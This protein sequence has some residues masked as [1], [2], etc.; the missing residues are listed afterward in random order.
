[1]WPHILSLLP[2]LLLP[3]CVAEA[4]PLFDDDKVVDI[5]LIG[6]V[7][8]LIKPMEKREEM[9]FVL[10]ANGAEHEVMVRLRGKS[11]LRVCKFPP[12]RLRFNTEDTDPGLFTGQ[13][14]LRLVTHCKNNDKGE[15]NVLEEYAAYRIF[16]LLSDYAYRVRLFR[17]RYTDT[18]QKLSEK[19]ALRYGFAIEPM[20]QLAQR[21]GGEMLHVQSLSAS[22]YNREQA[23]LVFVFQYLIGNTDWSFV[24]AENDDACCHNGDLLEIDRSIYYI[25]YDFDLAGIVNAN[26]AKPDPGLRMKN[27][28]QRRYRG[29]CIDTESVRTALQ[30]VKSQQA[31][32]LAVADDL[33][34]LA[35]AERKTMKDYLGQFFEKAE[36]EEKLLQLYEKRCLGKKA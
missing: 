32:V 22:R 16:A 8:S 23:A 18:D 1:M 25:P 33:P 29:Y 20:E 12:L 6:P 24:L 30:Y 5:E 15:I 9:P 13:D 17:I 21:A 28:R 2:T 7:Y 36:N 31:S 35:D 10:R 14:K 26:Y 11:R 4:A 19:A 3:L 34:G 27:V